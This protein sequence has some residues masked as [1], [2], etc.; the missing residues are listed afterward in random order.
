MIEYPLFAKN[1]SLR[2]DCP[3]CGQ[4]VCYQ[5]ENLPS[6]NWDG[7]TVESSQEM[8]TQE[9]Q[10]DSCGHDFEVDLYA[11]IYYGEL[12]VHESGE[13]KEIENIEITEEPEEDTIIP[14]TDM[15]TDLD[16]FEENGKGFQNMLERL[17]VF[18]CRFSMKDDIAFS[19]ADITEDRDDYRYDFLRGFVSAMCFS[20]F[21]GPVGCL[22]VLIP[23]Y[24]GSEVYF[25]CK[26][27]KNDVPIANDNIDTKFLESRDYRL[28]SNYFATQQKNNQKGVYY[29]QSGVQRMGFD[30]SQTSLNDDIF[31]YC[32][33]CA[34]DNGLHDLPVNLI[35]QNT[36]FYRIVEAYGFSEYLKQTIREHFYCDF[37]IQANFVSGIKMDEYFDDYTLNALVEKYESN[38]MYIKDLFVGIKTK[39]DDYKK[40][41]NT[42]EGHK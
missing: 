23:S 27:I 8:D 33:K 5:A 32:M 11:N 24:L 38:Q 37:E 18:A 31:L 20:R 16:I 3:R 13:L 35:T 17:A 22:K 21:V 15:R 12:C 25:V 34:R 29:T 42:L 30:I 28:L 10:C 40:F 41:I 1:I 9:F 6:P 2:F 19:V 14:I 36:P 39:I 4:Q 26:S 7:D